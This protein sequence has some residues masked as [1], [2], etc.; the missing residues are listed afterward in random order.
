MGEAY[1]IWFKVGPCICEE[2][3][4]IEAFAVAGMQLGDLEGD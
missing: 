3:L 1:E 4:A 2:A